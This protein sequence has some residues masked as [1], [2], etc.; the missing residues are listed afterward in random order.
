MCDLSNA[1]RKRGAFF[2]GAVVA[3]SGACLRAW[4][5]VNPRLRFGLVDCAHA[6]GTSVRARGVEGRALAG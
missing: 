5:C 6:L 3:T 4:A 1:L 2:I